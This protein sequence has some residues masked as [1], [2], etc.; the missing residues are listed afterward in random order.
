MRHQVS[1]PVLPWWGWLVMT[2]PKRSAQRVRVRRL[3]G[4]PGEL[5]ADVLCVGHGDE[6]R[7]G[8]ICRLLQQVDQADCQCAH[9]QW[10]QVRQ[11]SAI[12]GRVV[13]VDAGHRF[14]CSDREA[15]IGSVLA[16]A[17]SGRVHGPGGL[18]RLDR[19]GAERAADLAVTPDPRCEHQAT[20]LGVTIEGQ[21]G[22]LASHLDPDGYSRDLA[23]TGPGRQAWR[24]GGVPLKL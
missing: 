16:R 21:L 13:D 7:L 10:R 6:L 1:V 4:S 2:L 18:G 3:A 12:A 20:D 5:Q 9:R 15:E 23:I 11:C 22:L 17:R 19:I 24:A 8:Q 14:S